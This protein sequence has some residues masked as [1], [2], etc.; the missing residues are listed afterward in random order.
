MTVSDVVRQHESKSDNSEYEDEALV[1]VAST[2]PRLTSARTSRA[3]SKALSGASN[4]K[5][6][7]EFE[8]RG[9]RRSSRFTGKRYQLDEDVEMARTTDEDFDAPFDQP[10]SVPAAH[11]SRKRRTISPEASD[12]EEDGSRKKRAL[13]VSRPA[14]A[15]EGSSAT[16]SLMSDGTP[17]VMDSSS[18]LSSVPSQEDDSL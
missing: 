16:P 8:W 4:R 2:S 7:A 12:A 9:E 1:P 13:H 17:D 10:K 11:R 6:P 5:V 14:I 18:P 3:S 15:D